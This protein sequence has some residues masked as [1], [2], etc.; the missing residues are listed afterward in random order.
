MTQKVKGLSTKPDNLSLNPESTC[1]ERTTSL[2]LSSDFHICVTV[3]VW[4]LFVVSQTEPP[5]LSNRAS[6]DTCWN[7]AM[8]FLEILPKVTVPN[9]EM[10]VQ[11]HS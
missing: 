9:T 4:Q 10:S 8:V 7:I 11:R 1:Q 5:P 6:P 2:K 3:Y